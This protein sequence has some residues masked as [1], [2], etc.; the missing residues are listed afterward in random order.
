M[1]HDDKC[2][3]GNFEYDQNF[4]VM[5]KEWEG[6]PVYNKFAY[7]RQMVVEDRG[8]WFNVKVTGKHSSNYWLLLS[9]NRKR[10]KV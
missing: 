9:C 10:Q 2:V 6:G 7:G 1:N 3:R 8:V 5:L 4:F